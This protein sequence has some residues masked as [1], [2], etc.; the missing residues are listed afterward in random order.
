MS[1]KYKQLQKKPCEFEATRKAFHKK[2]LFIS[3]QEEILL[4]FPSAAPFP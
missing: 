1:N 4:S 3:Q 2:C